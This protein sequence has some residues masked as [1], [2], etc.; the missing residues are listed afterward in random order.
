MPLVTF[1]DSEERREHRTPSAWGAGIAQWLERRI[2]DWK[3]AGTNPCR[4]SGRIF[5]SRVSWSF[6]AGSYF[7]IRSSPV[8]P[9][10]H[11][12]DP[13]HS[14]KSAGSRLQLIRMH[15]TYV[16]LHEMTWCMVVWCVRHDSGGDDVM[17]VAAMVT[18]AVTTTWQW[19]WWWQWRCWWHDV[20]GSDDDMTSVAVTMAWRQWRWRWHDVS[21]GD[22][23]MTSVAVTMTWQWRWHDVSGG[24]DDMTVTMPR[25]WRWRWHNNGGDEDSNDDVASDTAV[26]RGTE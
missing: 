10:L 16:A 24:D 5:F 7:C 12:K 9:Q 14:A 20:S 23:G 26:N 1:S 3:V 18:V 25:Q 8:L 4:S 22:D 11:V 15:L 21:G 13:G 6:C 2:R 17:T 19:R